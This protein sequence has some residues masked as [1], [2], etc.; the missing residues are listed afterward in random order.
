MRLWL[1]PL[2]VFAADLRDF[3]VE[4]DEDKAAEQRQLRMYA[5]MG[6][7]KF[8]LQENDVLIAKTAKRT[9]HSVETIKEKLM[10]DIVL[11]C[12]KSI[13]LELAHELM[14]KASINP[15]D[16]EVRKWTLVD[17]EQFYTGKISLTREQEDLITLAEDDRDKLKA[18]KEKSLETPSIPS[19]PEIVNPVIPVVAVGIT[20]A[21][22][23]WMLLRRRKRSS[24][25]KE[26]KNK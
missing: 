6:V 25:R 2:F 14:T 1:L 8:W 22:V 7:A 3:Q 23:V 10:A 20:A 18:E 15:H 26:R 24:G 9:P 5:C 16:K 17:W 19:N 12:Y 21:V 11:P 13:T 4:I